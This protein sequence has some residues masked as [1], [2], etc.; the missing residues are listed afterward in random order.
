LQNRPG[1]NKFSLYCAAYQATMDITSDFNHR[2]TALEIVRKTIRETNADK[3]YQHHLTDFNNQNSFDANKS[4]LRL[5]RVN[6]QN[7]LNRISK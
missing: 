2:G 7:N 4:R 1:N 5:S 6:L 3:R